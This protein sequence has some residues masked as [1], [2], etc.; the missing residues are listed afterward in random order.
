MRDAALTASTGSAGLSSKTLMCSGF[1]NGLS[2]A[3]INH[4]GAGRGVVARGKLHVVNV[5]AG[6]P[7]RRAIPDAARAG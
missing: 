7:R 4:A 1:T 6:Q 2:A 3:K 5:K